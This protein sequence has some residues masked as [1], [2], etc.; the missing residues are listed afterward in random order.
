MGKRRV[1]SE[2]EI[3]PR[4]PREYEVLG[5]VERLLGFDRVMVRCLDGNTRL[6][7][8]RGKM[9]RR[10]WVRVNDVV[11]VSPWEFQTDSRGDI[12]YRYRRNQVDWL[13]ANG[14]LKEITAL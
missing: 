3:K 2:S 5:F 1:V 12:V 7:R 4:L 10:V 8:I 14:Y 6:C 11:I 13:R 9:K